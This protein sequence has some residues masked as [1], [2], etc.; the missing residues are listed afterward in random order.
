ME[1]EIFVKAKYI[2]CIL[3]TCLL[4]YIALPYFT[5]SGTTLRILFE[6]TWLALAFVVISGNVVALL[7]SV[8]RSI[9]PVRKKEQ[10]QEGKRMYH[11][12]SR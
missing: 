8:E 7:F 10:K 3:V 12:S 4:L 5:F 6:G 11:S 9:R 1:G 2:L